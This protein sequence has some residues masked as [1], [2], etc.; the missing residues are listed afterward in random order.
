[1][2]EEEIGARKKTPE[3]IEAESKKERPMSKTWIWQKYYTSH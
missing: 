1:M 3:E 2:P